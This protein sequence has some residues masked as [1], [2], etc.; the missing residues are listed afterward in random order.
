[1][2]KV[3]VT[4]ANGHLG[5]AL[6]RA[7]IDKNYIV[8]AGVRDPADKSRNRTLDGLA[9]ELVPIDLLQ[10]E[11][12][13]AA[14]SG[15]EGLFHAAAVYQ[16]VSRNPEK[17][18]VEPTV[19][20]SRNALLAAADAG[21]REIVYTSSVAAV[22][23]HAPPEKPLTED[24]WNDGAGNP[25]YYAKTR[26]E[27]E[28]WKGAKDK[29]LNLIAINPAV[30]I[31]PGFYRHTPSTGPFEMILRGKVPFSMPMGFTFVDVRDVA[32]A[33][34]C[35]YE[36]PKASGRYL[37]GDAYYEIADLMPVIRELFPKAKVPAHRAP[38]WTLPFLAA[39][40]WMTALFTGAP[41]LLT[42][43]MIRETAGKQMRL[44]S[45]K[46]RRELGWQPRPFRDSLRETLNWIQTQFIDKSK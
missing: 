44:S 16:T 25:Y 13:R 1:M 24:V 30:I 39:G 45:D 37:C 41:R 36:N 23:A 46:L 40:D 42:L 14:M 6:C 2:P 8:R 17:E 3:L 38:R 20:G 43:S 9:V 19:T 5:G 28:A 32:D 7:L 31:G 29:Q 22:G 10:P 33:H 11:S 4:G 15:C 27:R 18:V 35:A 12:L 21:V 34:L 26:S